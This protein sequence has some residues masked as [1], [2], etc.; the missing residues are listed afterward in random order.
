MYCKKC[1]KELNSSMKFC[2]ACGAAVEQE[3]IKPVKKKKS[4]I[5]II[6]IVILFIVAATIATMM[7]LKQN[8]T[9]KYVTSLEQGD[10]YLEDL[11][12]KNA[13]AKYLAAIEIEPKEK[14][15]YLKLADVYMNQEN[16]EKAVSILEKGIENTNDE[17]MQ[18]RYNLYTYVDKVLIPE[19][20]Q[21]KEGEYP[22]N[23]VKKVVA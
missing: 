22:C 7:A 21:C 16:I 5:W 8:K 19:I 15:P 3:K 10:K 17:E 20:G 9:K 18:G 23:Y 1:G 2:P 13:E 6:L 4:L 14:K 11:D 12:Y